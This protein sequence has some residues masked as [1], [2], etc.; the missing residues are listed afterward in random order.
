[1]KDESINSNNEANYDKFVVDNSYDGGEPGRTEQPTGDEPSK[2]LEFGQAKYA[3]RGAGNSIY[4]DP[5]RDTDNDTRAKEIMDE[6]PTICE[7]ESEGGA[8]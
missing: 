7:D 1:M 3:K 4:D 8:Y 6:K 5:T 2:G